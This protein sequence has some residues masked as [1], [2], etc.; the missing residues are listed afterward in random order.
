[1]DM[2]RKFLQMGWTRAR[3]YANHPS[4]PKYVKGTREKLPTLGDPV[5]AKSAAIFRAV[6]LRA[7]KDRVY[8]KLL[9]AHP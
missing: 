6:Y 4:G 7:L 8:R 9:A 3:R 1:M 2:A 5:K